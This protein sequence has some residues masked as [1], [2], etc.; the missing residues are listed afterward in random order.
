MAQATLTVAVDAELKASFTAAAEAAAL[1]PEELL[2]SLMQDYVEGRAAI[3]PAY[4]AWFRSEVEAGLREAEAGK[5]V[6]NEEVEKEFARWR[7]ET[8]RKLS[9]AP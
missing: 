8:L 1:S 5:L 2:H 6:P 3:D 4:D 9:T 7:A